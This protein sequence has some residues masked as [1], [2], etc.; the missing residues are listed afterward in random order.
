VDV[1]SYGVLTI[2]T[3]A[4]PTNDFQR[5]IA[6]NDKRFVAYK[7]NTGGPLP[8]YIIPAAQGDDTKQCGV[9]VITGTPNVF[10]REVASRYATAYNQ[11]LLQHLR[12]E[13][14]K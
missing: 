2:G 13:K 1:S 12:A 9:K 8:G 6:T 10:P 5:A 4:N 3:S 11:L 7:Y 14:A